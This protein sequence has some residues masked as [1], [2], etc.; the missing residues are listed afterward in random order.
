MA[1]GSVGRDRGGVDGR[2][3]NTARGGVVWKTGHSREPGDERTML[4]DSQEK[5]NHWEKY[6]SGSTLGTQGSEQGIIIEDIEH[7]LGVRI[8]LERA[9]KGAPYRITCGIYGRMVH[10]CSFSSLHQAASKYEEMKSDL[11]QILMHKDDTNLA[12][13]IRNF[14]QKFDY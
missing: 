8:T 6:Q 2:M 14:V 10:T 12:N 5:D 13:E 7:D 4:V 11:G 3:V 1:V 9:F